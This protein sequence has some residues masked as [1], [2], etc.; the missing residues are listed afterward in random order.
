MRTK[1]GILLDVVKLVLCAKT[2]DK[3]CK[4]LLPPPRPSGQ[5]AT[6]WACKSTLILFW[7]LPLTCVRE[8]IRVLK[9]AVALVLLPT[10]SLASKSLSFLLRALLCSRGRI[11]THHQLHV[12]LQHVSRC[13][14]GS[15]DR[16]Q[17]LSS[18][19]PPM[20]SLASWGK[21]PLLVAHRVERHFS[22]GVPPPG[23]TR[24][25]SGHSLLGGGRVWDGEPFWLLPWLSVPFRLQLD[26]PP[27]LMCPHSHRCPRGYLW[28][29]AA[30]HDLVWAEES[31]SQSAEEWQGTVIKVRLKMG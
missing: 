15:C 14:S 20:P 10:L 1:G 8:L 23:G 5:Q 11:C 19:L 3:A 30:F 13:C 4:S 24:L 9:S 31:S 6:R 22:G 21:R 2:P 25:W 12:E 16:E 18:I 26:H 27:A 17:C 29:L 28:I 7:V